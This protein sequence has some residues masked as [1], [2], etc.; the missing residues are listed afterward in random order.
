VDYARVKRWVDAS[1]V[2]EA[3]EKMMLLPAQQ[4]G[5]L[6]CR[7]LAEFP[8]FLETQTAECGFRTKPIA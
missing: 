7:L 5:R 6:D 3:F 2:L 8:S 4:L 1:Q